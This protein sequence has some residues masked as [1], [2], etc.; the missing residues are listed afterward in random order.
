M[1]KQFDTISLE[2]NTIIS[3]KDRKLEGIYFTPKNARDVI[4]NQ[5]DS[6]IS[7]GKWKPSS[8][9]EPSFGSGEF[10]KDI[11]KYN[12][13]RVV[14]IEKNTV[15]YDKIKPLYSSSYNLIN[16]D[17][18]DFC[19]S[20]KF[21]LIIGNP[22]YFTLD[23]SLR[24]NPINKECM[25]GS[26]NI[27]VLFIYKCLTQH[28][29]NKGILAFV[30]PTSFYNCKYYEPC[31]KYISNNCKIIYLENL[32]VKYVDTEQN[33]M[34]LI[35][36]NKSSSSRPFVLD[37]PTNL[38][39]SP[40][41]KQIKTLKTQCTLLDLGFKV[42]TGEIVW[43]Q[44]KPEL[45]DTE[46]TLLIYSGNL[47]KDPVLEGDGENILVLHNLSG[48]KKQ[49]IKNCSK[50]PSKGPAILISRGYGNN[51][52]FSYTVIRDEIEFYGEN[53]INI[54]YPSSSNKKNNNFEKIISSL[55]DPRTTQ[56]IKLYVGNGA[57]SKTE[58][59]SILPIF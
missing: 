39:F 15:I 14:G 50:P 59:E 34:V 44:N 3:K 28:L 4:I 27:F 45:S 2:L 12:S 36:K 49:Y 41:Y 33:T 24:S 42:K 10:L 56:F 51:Y 55:K 8:I 23:K 7:K 29:S 1:T 11:K 54:I 53:H 9:L 38:C 18:C 52:V 19:D 25:S 16:V 58:I 35:L 30:L 46:G 57:L 43:N 48:E 26:G 13:K 6:I 17:F 32:N 37:F 20:D 47:K 22:P 5:L 21:D 31:R 40:F